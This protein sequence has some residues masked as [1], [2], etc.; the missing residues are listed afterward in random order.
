MASLTEGEREEHVRARE[1]AEGIVPT[2]DMRSL[3][4]A[5]LRPHA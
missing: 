2:P 1:A 3:A 5:M 4:L